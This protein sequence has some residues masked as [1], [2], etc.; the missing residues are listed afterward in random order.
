MTTHVAS[1][2]LV[3]LSEKG[4]DKDNLDGCYDLDK[5]Q[6]QNRE[7]HQGYR[8]EDIAQFDKGKE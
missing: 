2:P 8:R 4:K 3:G 1:D 5:D 7:N 6:A